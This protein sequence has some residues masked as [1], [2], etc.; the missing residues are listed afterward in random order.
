V[1]ERESGGDPN[2]WNASG[3]YG[4]YQFSESTWIAYG[5]PASEFGNATVAEQNQ[6]FATA[7]AEGG[8]SNWSLYD[9]C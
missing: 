5:G 6:V 1:V 4:L 2:I 9:G 7:L 3:H 8:E